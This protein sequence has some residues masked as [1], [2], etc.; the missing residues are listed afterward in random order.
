[1]TV[2][3]AAGHDSR[4]VKPAIAQASNIPELPKLTRAISLRLTLSGD[5]I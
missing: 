2:W 1:M 5:L 3:A 4:S